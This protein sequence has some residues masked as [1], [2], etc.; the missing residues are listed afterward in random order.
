M[1]TL[2]HCEKKKGE[3]IHQ[4]L[5]SSWAGLLGWSH[6]ITITLP[7]IIVDFYAK[8]NGGLASVAAQGL[9]IAYKE[10]IQ[11]SSAVFCVS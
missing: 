6:I 10:K 4:A 2:G 1:S 8:S 9:A 7:I 5:S 3:A 11:H